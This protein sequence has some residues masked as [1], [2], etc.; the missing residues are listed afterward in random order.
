L[1]HSKKWKESHS[2]KWKDGSHSK[3]W[4]VALKEVDVLTTIRK[5]CSDADL[6][7]KNPT[8]LKKVLVREKISSGLSLS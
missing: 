5:I 8:S 2:K 1:S 7:L 6:S 3:K 4:M